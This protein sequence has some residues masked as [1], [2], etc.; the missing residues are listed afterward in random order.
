MRK[1]QSSKK[2]SATVFVVVFQLF[3]LFFVGFIGGLLLTL[4]FDPMPSTI[5]GILGIYLFIFLPFGLQIILHEGG[6]LVM[7]LLTGYRFHSFRIGKWMWI[8]REGKIRFGRFHLPGTGGQCILIPPP[9][10]E[11]GT[12]PTALYN[13]GGVLFNLVSAIIAVPL[14]ILLRGN[15]YVAFFFAILAL[16]GIYSAAING[17]PFKGTMIANDAVNAG[18]VAKSP[19]SMR[20][21][22]ISH[23]TVQEIANGKHVYE[24]P[25]E[26]FVLPSEEEMQNS[27]TTSLAVLACD[28]KM[29]AG[30]YVGAKELIGYLLTAPIALSDFHRNM[31]K[32]HQIVCLLLTEQRN[33]EINALLTK[34][35]K[36]FIQMLSSTLEGIICQYALS[37]LWEKDSKKSEATL[38]QFAKIRAQYPYPVEAEDAEKA[39][40]RIREKAKEATAVP[41]VPPQGG[42]L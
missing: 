5:F 6:H 40:H 32:M 19:A 27:F 42:S 14:T 36:K 11:D 37:M 2:Q 15:S 29:S 26:W 16:A 3:L 25:D 8:K 10:N 7:G 1:T 24:L 12:F 28:R 30:D 31:L 41:G 23:E 35:Q 9:A 20:A 38:A 17:I 39:L 33:D 34:E 22:R 13:W 21:L 4:L 18:L